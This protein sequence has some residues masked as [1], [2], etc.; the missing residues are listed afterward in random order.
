MNK[1]FSVALFNKTTA[2]VDRILESERKGD[3]QIARPELLNFDVQARE[4]SEI[5]RRTSEI[6]SVLLGVTLVIVGAPVAIQVNQ[7]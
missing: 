5:L 2:I 1:E 3:K 4:R 6:L 7:Q